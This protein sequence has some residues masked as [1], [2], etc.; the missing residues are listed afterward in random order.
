M[1]APLKGVLTPNASIVT[2]PSLANPP[3]LTPPTVSG[4]NIIVNGEPYYGFWVNIHF[5]CVFYT[6]LLYKQQALIEAQLDNLVNLGVRGVRIHGMDL[7]TGNNIFCAPNGPMTG[8]RTLDQN[9]LETLDW[10]LNQ[11][12]I[13]NLRVGLTLH[14]QRQL[15]PADAP[16][17]TCQSF[18]EL[19]SIKRVYGDPAGGLPDWMWVDPGVAEFLDDFNGHLLAYIGPYTGMPIGK[20][21]GL[22][23][24]SVTNEHSLV[25][26]GPYSYS[27][28]VFTSLME[29]LAQQFAPT[30]GVIYKSENSLNK[31]D[32]QMCLAWIEN[33]F[34]ASRVA[35]LRPLTSAL[36]IC[37]SYYGYQPYNTI[38]APHQ[39]GD[40]VDFHCYSAYAAGDPNHLQ[41]GPGANAR[42][43]WGG[44]A[45]ACDYGDKPAICTEWGPQ[46][47]YGASPLDPP[48]QLA[49][50]MP[51]VVQAAI[52]QHVKIIAPYCYSQSP[53]RP[54]PNYSTGPYDLCVCPTFLNGCRSL[55]AQF[56]DSDLR[57]TSRVP[58]PLTNASLYGSGIGPAFTQGSPQNDLGLYATPGR[59]VMTPTGT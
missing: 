19:I 35:A 6:I 42:S 20:H 48:A 58:Y 21:P 15:Q 28:P 24:L 16:P 57:P 33:R 49:T 13:R 22:T 2:K 7:G 59:L 17:W 8:T 52:N 5:W 44:I 27:T 47:Q 45:A 56:H 34:Y 54:D 29:S 53:F 30:I 38:T 10:F 12:Y 37:G 26:N 31:V 50:D 3:I 18:Q 4:E 11:C 40:A 43:M 41:V 1:M 32:W 55:I 25:R 9:S 46:G 39:Q 51:A 23:F 36:V 14:Y